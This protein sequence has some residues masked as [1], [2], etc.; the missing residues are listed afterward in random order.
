VTQVHQTVES[1]ANELN[2]EHI[3]VQ[4]KEGIMTKQ[5]Q[6]TRIEEARGKSS[7]ETRLQLLIFFL[8]L[9]FVSGVSLV[10]SQQAIAAGDDTRGNQLRGDQAQGDQ[11]Q[12]DQLQGDQLQGD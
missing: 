6:E 5:C 10:P 9:I 3:D 2:C 12:G 1:L 7:R 11:L 4:R 8:A